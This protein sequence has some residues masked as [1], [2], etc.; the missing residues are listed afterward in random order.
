[1][2][3]HLWVRAR[4]AEG[5][6]ERLL[7]VVRHR[8]FA[9]LSLTADAAYDGTVMEIRMQLNGQRS[10]DNLEKQIMKLF[11]V[12]S[13]EREMPHLHKTNQVEAPVREAAI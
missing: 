13:V 12:Q 5:F 9:V 6:L 11:D 3:H 7:G 1:M 4:N 10:I 8:G 2:S